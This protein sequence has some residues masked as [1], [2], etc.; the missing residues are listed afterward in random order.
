MK[1][2]GWLTVMGVVLAICAWT[3]ARAEERP[4][5]HYF[6]DAD[7]DG[8]ITG[9]DKIAIANKALGVNISYPNV[10]PPLWEVQDVD[11]D[12]I[13]TGSDKGI[14]ANWSFGLYANP[15]G[16][17]VPV[18]IEIGDLFPIVPVW[19]ATISARLIP[20]G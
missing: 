7:G 18:A 19:G 1:R 20:R 6:G 10:K 8:I 5:A 4:G 3:M 15:T 13:P 12:L 17:G 11:G 14:I 9:S 2:L 16:V